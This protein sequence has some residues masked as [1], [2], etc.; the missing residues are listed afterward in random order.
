M[1]LT[2][3][4][5]MVILGEKELRIAAQSKHIAALEAKL[6]ELTASEKHKPI[7]VELRGRADEA[8]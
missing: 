8:A 6:Q 2:L 7:A 4:E 3:Q 1:E 5:V